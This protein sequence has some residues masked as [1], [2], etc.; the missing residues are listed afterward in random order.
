MARLGG[1]EFA[2]LLMGCDLDKAQ[3]IIEG[4]LQVVREYRFTF[5]DKVFKVGASV[6]LTEISPNQNLDLSELLS[7]SLIHI[8][9]L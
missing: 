2:L 5:D 8:S 3:E 7:L 9:L 6:G 1:D 4:L